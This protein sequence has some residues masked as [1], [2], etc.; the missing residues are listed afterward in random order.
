MS[1]HRAKTNRA[2]PINSQWMSFASLAFQLSITTTGACFTHFIWQRS[3][4]PHLHLL[5]GGRRLCGERHRWGTLSCIVKLGRFNDPSMRWPT[6]SLEQHAVLHL[7]KIMEAFSPAITAAYSNISIQALKGEVLNLRTCLDFTPHNNKTA[8][9]TLE[10]D[11]LTCSSAVQ[12]WRKWWHRGW[13][14]LALTIKPRRSPRTKLCINQRRKHDPGAPVHDWEMCA[15]CSVV[16]WAIY[17]AWGCQNVANVSPLDGEASLSKA[18]EGWLF[19]ACSSLLLPLSRTHCLLYQ[20]LL[21]NTQTVHFQQHFSALS[22]AGGRGVRAG[23]RLDLENEL[24]S[25]RND[26]QPLRNSFMLFRHS[27]SFFGSW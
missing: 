6:H 27:P 16:V 25:T 3:V 15:R 17:V 26:V 20:R 8:I 21:L 9:T 5:F 10:Q 24:T 7:L 18:G 22:H 14:E 1:L 13:C 11:F 2:L 12:S 19:S 23:F 4:L